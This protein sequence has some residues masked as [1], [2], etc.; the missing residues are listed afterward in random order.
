LVNVDL[1]SLSLPAFTERSKRLYDLLIENQDAVVM[2]PKIPIKNRYLVSLLLG[3]IAFVIV[4]LMSGI[5]KEYFDEWEEKTLDYRFRNRKEIPIY[6]YIST[7]GI[8]QSSLE[9]VGPWPWDRSIHGRMVDLL[10][11][12]GASVIFFDIFFPAPSSEAGDAQF[13]QSVQEAG[14]VL[15]ASTY[16][17]IDHPCFTPREYREFLKQYPKAD[18]ILQSLKQEKYNGICIDFNALTP[19]Q[20]NELGQE[21]ALELLY[22]AEFVF[23]SEEEEIKFEA[24][25]EHVQYPFVARH[26]EKLW[27]ANRALLSLAPLIQASDGVGHVTLSPD[28]DGVLRRVPLVIQVSDRLIPHLALLA[29][30]R[31]LHVP[32][33]NVEIVPGKYITLHDA[34]FPETGRVTD[35]K[36]PVDERAQL[37]IN[38]LP[39]WGAHVFAEVLDSEDDQEMYDYWKKELPGH[40][41]TVGYIATGT[42][43]MGPNP[44][45]SKFPYALAQAAIMNTIL[46][47]NFLYEIGDEVTLGITFV[48]LLGVS[49]ISP[50]LSPLRFTLFVFLVIAGYMTTAIVLFNLYGIILKLINPVLIVLVLAYTLITTY[51]YATEERERK[52]LRSAFKTYVSRQML[53]KILDNPESLKLTGQ[54]KEMTIMFSDVRKFSTLSDKIQPEVI[55][56]LLNMYFSR[57]TE[58]AFQYD[59]FVDKFIGDGLLCFFGDPIPHK[60]H[61]LRAVQAAIEMQQAVRELGPIIQQELK[62]DPIVIRIGLNTGYV[63]VG[64]MGSAERMEYTVLGSEVNLAQ[65]LE[66][67]ATPGEVMIS[68]NTY[69]HVKDHIEVRD[70]GEIQVKGFE[71]YIKV[72]EVNLPFE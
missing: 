41:C 59:G 22:R 9:T 7:I 14:N 72:Y 58:I 17:L 64:N 33:E 40:I 49:L 24:L 27:Y 60:D 35:I 48:L 5:F 46:T 1:Q 44:Y 62:M 69:Q 13:I 53:E 71:R 16:E 37:R 10:S 26:P 12:F 54:R 32:P 23:T 56:R 42:G 65:R 61:A 38:F 47:Q 20:W 55:H 39:S 36:I 52:Q 19:E 67:S 28:S 6:P 51:W 63:I 34:R 21:A 31:Y 30:M 4:L 2:T 29:V 50:K 18:A 57:M 66:S 70:M 25:R 43:D 11:D 3:L 8:E 45:E 68:E 15:L